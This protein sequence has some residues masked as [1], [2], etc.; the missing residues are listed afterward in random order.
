M[1]KL[2]VV[3]PEPGASATLAR[4]LGLGLDAFKLPLFDVAALD[5]S[6]PGAEEFNGILLTSANAL[7]HGGGAL[8]ALRGLPAYAVGDTTAEAARAAGFAIAAT[9]GEGVES[10]LASL[11]PG[12]RLFHPC[13]RDH[14]PMQFARQAITAIP[15]YDARA[16]AVADPRRLN[17]CVI[18][19]HSPRAAHRLAALADDRGTI[20]VAAISPAAAEAA[21]TGWGEVAAADTPDDGALLALAARLCKKGSGE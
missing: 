20:R 11:S 15:V 9:G 18:M 3:R 16:I 12:L 13:G 8:E 10:L 19:I 5:W 1:R 6:P 2:A 14:V 17:G 7:R 21:G 4:A